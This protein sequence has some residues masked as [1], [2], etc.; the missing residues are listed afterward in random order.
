MP[1]SGVTILRLGLDVRINVVVI[2][3]NIVIVGVGAF[4]PVSASRRRSRRYP[5]RLAH[6][7]TETSGGIVSEN[8]LRVREA[9]IVPD[10]PHR[11]GRGFGCRIL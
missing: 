4:A 6:A 3:I 11:S 7:A 9:M 10:I 8:R 2:Q 1:R 5:P